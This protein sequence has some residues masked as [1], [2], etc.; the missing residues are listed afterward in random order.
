MKNKFFQTASSVLLFTAGLNA[1]S[2]NPD[3]PD[4]YYSYVAFFIFLIIFLMILG[5]LYY[6]MGEGEVVEVKKVSAFKK[7]RQFVT[8]SVPM[9]KEDDILLDHN[10]DGI[11]E[12]D[13]RVPPWFS[14]LFYFTILF[15]VYY[16]LDYHV[17]ATSKLSGD[18]YLEEVQI[19]AD[20]MAE[21]MKSGAL[22][23]EETVTAV[24]DEAS[25]LSGKKIYDVNCVAC[26]SA[27]GGGLVGPNLTDEYWIHGGGIK[28]VFKTIKYGVPAKGMISWQAQLNARQIQEVASFILTLKGTNPVNPKQPEGAIYTEPDSTAVVVTQ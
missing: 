23:N 21:L 3:L 16:M 7:F 26:H 22:V 4:N 13:N 17:F 12:L 1:Q 11:K 20:K 27:D 19:A 5:F 8:R 14:Y 24:F 28:N 2:G 10:Y 25:V 15:A 18:E 9:E 6:G